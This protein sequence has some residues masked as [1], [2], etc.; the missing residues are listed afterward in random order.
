MSRFAALSA[1][2]S[3]PVRRPVK[4]SWSRLKKQLIRMVI[5]YAESF[6]DKVESDTLSFREEFTIFALGGLIAQIFIWTGHLFS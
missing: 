3:H 2:R 5:D 4:I 1:R 6:A